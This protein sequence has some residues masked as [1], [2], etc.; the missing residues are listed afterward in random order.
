MWAVYRK[1]TIHLPDNDTPIPVA[2]NQQ[3]LGQHKSTVIDNWLKTYEQAQGE[4]SK[5]KSQYLAKVRKADDAEDEY[6]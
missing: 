2:P 5:L 1:L 6:V 4:V 3:R